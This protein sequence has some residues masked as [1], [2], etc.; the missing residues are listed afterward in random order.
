MPLFENIEAFKKLHR[1]LFWS[2]GVF[3]LFSLLRPGNVN[4]PFG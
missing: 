1:R 2:K 4:T 3:F